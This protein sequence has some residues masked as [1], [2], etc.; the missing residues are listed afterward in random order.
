ML[1]FLSQNGAIITGI[2]STL[3]GGG[4]VGAYRAYMSETRNS[5]GQSFD[6]IMKTSKRMEDRLVTVEKRLDEQGHTLRE[7][8]KQLNRSRIREE[9]LRAALDELVR[10]IDRLVKRLSK[11]EE[12]SADEAEK[13][14]SVPFV[15]PLNS[16]TN[17]VQRDGP[18]PE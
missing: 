3:A 12:I 5:T 9:E 2:I 6:Q 8:Q 13:L 18:T 15:G 1:E 4:L 7:A 16:P 10:R 14:K 17:N 11:H